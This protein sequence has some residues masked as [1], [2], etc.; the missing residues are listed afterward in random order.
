MKCQLLSWGLKHALIV[1][2]LLSH[3]ALIDRSARADDP[4]PGTALK[5]QATGS[6]INPVNNSQETRTSSS[7]MVTTDSDGCTIGSGTS[8]P[9]IIPYISGEVRRNVIATR[10]LVDIL[11]DDW[12]TAVGQPT[13][14]ALEN[15]FGTASVPQGS[16]NNFSYH[17]PV[18]DN[19][20][21][22][23][24]ELV[25][26]PIGETAC[27]G[28]PTIAGSSPTLSSSSSLQGSAPRPTSLYESN[29]QPR[30]WNETHA[31]ALSDLKRNT[32]LLSFDQPVSS[33]GFWV[34]DLETRTDG[35]GTPAI[36]RLLDASNNRIGN[37]IEIAPNSLYDSNE[38]DPELVVQSLCG[39]TANNEPGC[40]NQSTRW[41]G[42]VDN[43]EIERIQKV[44]LIVGDDD[45]TAGNNNADSEHLSFIG[46]NVFR[47]PEVLVVK[48][49]TAINGNRTVNLNDN[50]PLN[51]EVND[52]IANS[53]DDNR[54]WPTDY[55]IGEINA[56]LVKPG[57]EIEYTI[58]FIN[59]GGREAM[60]V[61][62]CDW[63][64][65]NQNFVTGLY[66][67]SAP[68][69]YDGKDIAL[70]IGGSTYQL[71][72]TNDVT[73]RAELTTVG[74]LSTNPTCNLSDDTALND[75]VLVLDVTGT[76]GEPTG[77]TT[78]PGI[79]GQDLPSNAFG[80]F[81]FT[82]QVVE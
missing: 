62:L 28:E 39:G 71:T 48:R 82:T 34:G 80:F 73:D 8:D 66:G 47:P 21:N 4:A 78:L 63:I 50:T 33:F 56:G 12:R 23:S 38:P 43:G 58:Y 6:F 2:I 1:I 76:I 18:I 60:D 79:S 20:V 59:T 57:D 31:G 32:V 61:R 46:A 35:N 69:L 17:D 41:I 36:L 13:D 7:V 52:N 49:I 67:A 45:S 74:S 3:G 26:I 65:P 53:A 19:I 51:T 55:L 14:P 30:F 40:G 27:A 81:R 15:W 75:N 29:D 9:S 11:D 77:L 72:A 42:F 68:N 22:V 64:Q 16:V 54:N 25:Q 70:D 44:M 24:V 5:N 37:D 10:D